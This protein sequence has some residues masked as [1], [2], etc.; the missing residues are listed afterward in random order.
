MSAPIPLNRWSRFHSMEPRHS[1]PPELATDQRK[2]SEQSLRVRTSFSFELIIL[3]VR[4]TPPR[5]TVTSC[6]REG[7]SSRLI[8]PDPSSLDHLFQ[9][10]LHLVCVSGRGI[11]VCL[12]VPHNTRGRD[13][14]ARLTRTPDLLVVSEL[15]QHFGGYQRTLA[16][17]NLSEHPSAYPPERQRSRDGRAMEDRRDHL[18]ESGRLRSQ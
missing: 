11:A 6:K 12:P 17:L 18:V 14:W 1:M 3:L 2:F 16:Q 13:L 5:Y 10:D 7:R 9:P 4:S 15:R 8:A